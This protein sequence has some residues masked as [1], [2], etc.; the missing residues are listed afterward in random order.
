MFGRLEGL[1]RDTKKKR[2]RL[3]QPQRR[4]YQP[5]DKLTPT[6]NRNAIG[7]SCIQLLNIIGTRKCTV[8]LPRRGGP[9]P[10]KGPHR[11]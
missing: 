3:G 5:P 11:P 4:Q 8:R 1:C 7:T 2:L 9:K 10:C 6:Q